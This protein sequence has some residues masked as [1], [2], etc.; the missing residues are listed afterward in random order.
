MVSGTTA[1]TLGTDGG[2]AVEVPTAGL[3]NSS[4]FLNRQYKGLHIVHLPDSDGPLS[5]AKYT[6]VHS[7]LIRTKENI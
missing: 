3:F 5:Q 7:C 1:Q 4:A 2:R 6:R